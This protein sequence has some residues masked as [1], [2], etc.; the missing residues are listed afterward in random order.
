MV[1]ISVD[2][3][4]SAQESLLPLRSGRSCPREVFAEQNVA[5]RDVKLENVVWDGEVARLIDFDLAVTKV[6]VARAL[7]SISISPWF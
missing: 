7:P 6:R 2:Q 3:C 4:T 1:R 5:H